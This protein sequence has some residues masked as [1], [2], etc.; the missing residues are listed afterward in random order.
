MMYRLTLRFIM[1]TLIFLILTPF[2][3][4][5]VPESETAVSPTPLSAT[6]T[7]TGLPTAAV[8]ADP[9]EPPTAEPTAVP[10]LESSRPPTPTSAP[11]ATAS[12]YAAAEKQTIDSL[13]PA[14]QIKIPFV[15]EGSIYLYEDGQ[16][17][18]VAAPGGTTSQQACYNLTYPFLSPDGNTL[19]YLDQAGELPGEFWGCFYGNLRI[20]DLTTGIDTPTSY[21]I[22]S[23]RWTATNLIQF[24]PDRQVD[25]TTNQVIEKEIFIDPATQTEHHYETIYARDPETFAETMVT[26]EYPSDQL[27]QLIRF[28]DES[29]FL[30]D[31]AENEERFLFSKDEVVR[32]LGWSPGGRYALFESPVQATDIFGVIEYVVDTQNPDSKPVEIAVGRGAAG[33]DLPAGR[34][35][36]FEAGFVPYCREE[37]YF[38]DG[39]PLLQLT[40]DEGGGCNNEEGFVATSPNGNYALLKFQD[41]FELHDSQGNATIV[42]EVEPLAKGR[43]M[44]K[45]FVWLNNDFMVIYQAT[46]GFPASDADAPDIYLFD[47]AAKTIEPLI[48][49]AYLIDASP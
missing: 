22:L 26:A 30:V 48:E 4:A 34:K 18:L 12:S 33:G 47:R 3:T 21:R 45:N 35:W 13:N 7:P 19:A 24:R 20:V 5:C 40:N 36:Y 14:A 49:D 46:F 23:Y 11:T 38:V 37:M 44:P 31:V 41:R 43:G 42:E 27:T 17:K 1:F 29:Y 2:L 25:E 9:T 32:F 39:R 28:K 16:E 15:R 8:A 6:A 10:T